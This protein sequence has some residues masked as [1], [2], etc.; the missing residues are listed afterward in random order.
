M[1]AA[2]RLAASLFGALLVLGACARPQSTTSPGSVAVQEIAV[3]T[4]SA[5]AR[6]HYAL[7]ERLLDVGRPQEAIAHFR[8]AV[9]LDSTFASAYLG[10]ANAAQSTAEFKENLDAAARHVEGKSE[11]ERLLVDIARTFLSNDA[12]GALERAQRLT[13]LHPGSPRAWLVL[14]NAQQALNQHAAARESYQ[15]ALVLDRNMYAA[16]AALA[17][18]YRQFEPRDLAKAKEQAD[19]AVAAAP[20]EAKSHE[21]LGDVLRAMGELEQA[22]DAYARAVEKDSTLAVARLKVGHINSFL[23]NYAD[24]R[25][26][27]D[28]AL[29]GAR[30]ADRITYA[31][32]RAFAHVHA[33]D[34]RAALNELAQAERSAVRAEIP[35][36]QVGGLRIFTLTNAAVIALHAG[37]TREAELIINQLKTVVRA[38]AARVRDTAYTRQQEAQLLVWEG[39]LAARKGDFTTAAAKAE[40]HRKLVENDRNPRRLEAYHGLLGLI[41]LRKGN[42]AAAVQHYREANLTDEY[43][44]YHLALALEGAGQT[45]EAKRIFAQVGAFNFNSVGFA[46]VRADALKRGAGG[47]GG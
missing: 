8:Q 45:E 13:Q 39:Q 40:E 2:S 22:R 47:D 27:Y 28:A 7:G 15:R 41:E 14:G 25:A 9:A 21:L 16:R 44:R 3:T 33:G 35:E 26:S 31:N 32:F 18:S 19:L 42:H 10:L 23:G 29:A 30:E 46:L 38:D 20:D 6:S 24:A 5:E 4:G 17:F 37:M 12:E 36:Q 11:G 1:R 43:T 34:A